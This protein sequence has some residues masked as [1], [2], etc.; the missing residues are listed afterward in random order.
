MAEKVVVPRAE[1]VRLLGLPADVDEETLQRELAIQLAEI[2]AAKEARRVSAAEQAAR[3]EDRRIVLAAVNAGKFPRSRIEFWTDALQRDRENNRAVIASLAPG[4][5]PAE[6]LVVDAEVEAAHRRVLERLGIPT[7]KTVT[8]SDGTTTYQQAVR[9]ADGFGRSSGEHV[10]DPFV[11][12]D[13]PAPVRV[14]RG[15]PESE[16]TE[17]ERADAMQRRLGPRFYAGT[18][19]PPQGD[20]WFQPSPNQPYVF[21]EDSQQWREN[22]NYRPTG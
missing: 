16:L 20:K 11:I 21:D 8:A 19:P 2:E 7:P 13:I 3:A 1:V 10:P 4:L 17:R 12:P 6:Q 15:K 9:N 14:S 22:R 5:R 18:Q